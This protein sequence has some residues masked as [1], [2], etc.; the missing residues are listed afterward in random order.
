VEPTLHRDRYVEADW[1][2]QEVDR[3]FSAQWFC[4]GRQEEVPEP[5]DHLVCEVVGESVLVTRWLTTH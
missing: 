3:V 2:A 4:V 1:Y 5:G